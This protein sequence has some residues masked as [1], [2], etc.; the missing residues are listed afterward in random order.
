MEEV[1]ILLKKKKQPH[2]FE[3]YLPKVLKEASPINTL[4]SN[5]KQQLSSYICS[6]IHHL[7]TI[8]CRLTSM[9]KHKTLTTKE[10]SNALRFLLSGNLLT[11]TIEE[12]MKSVKA[13]QNSKDID[14]SI[15]SK[16]VRA[17][18]IFPPSLV[19]RLLRTKLE[20]KVIL[21]SLAPIFIAS[22]CEF[23]AYEILDLSTFVCKKYDRSRITINDIITAIEHDNEL[24]LL[25]QRLN[26]SFIGAGLPLQSFSLISNNNSTSTILKNIKTQ[27]KLSQTLVFNKQ[28]FKN[29]IKLILHN[30][31]G[32]DTTNSE[33]VSKLTYTILQYFIEEY[34]TDLLLK[35]NHLTI[36]AGRKKMI[37]NDISLTNYLIKTKS[38][39]KPFYE[40]NSN[41][42]RND[43]EFELFSC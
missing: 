9:S 31:R 24:S 27:T 22:V 20:N 16:Q 8:A 10:C 11:L 32:D 33:K 2:H 43:S 39:K 37:P 40:P 28:P 23:I 7:A 29:L 41:M 25:Y 34:I 38:I 18:L 5:A 3:I 21:S 17:G 26:T 15:I 13:F 14:K 30:H 36:H 42:K 4:T 19:E 6:F 1:K 35:A 12:G